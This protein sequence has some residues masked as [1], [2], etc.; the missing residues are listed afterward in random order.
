MVSELRANLSV[1]LRTFTRTFSEDD[2]ESSF[3]SS[4]Y[5]AIQRLMVDFHT[6]LA[7]MFRSPKNLM[8]A[9]KNLLT[10]I[11]P[12]SNVRSLIIGILC[13]R[14]PAIDEHERTI[15]ERNRFS[16]RLNDLSSPEQLVSNRNLT[17]NNNRLSNSQ[18][19]N[20]YSSSTSVA[21]SNSYVT[22]MEID[23]DLDYDFNSIINSEPWVKNCPRNWLRVLS[24][25]REKI[26]SSRQNAL[27]SRQRIR[28]SSIYKEAYK[29]N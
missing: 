16:S 26:L 21:S 15:L 18:R 22:P 29:R 14:I 13:Y 4:L 23:L 19:A 5:Q 6:S 20:Q 12:D 25:D 11:F 9:Y 10:T 27:N 1:F 28:F 8:R 2:G 24:R 17:L 7:Q 3:A